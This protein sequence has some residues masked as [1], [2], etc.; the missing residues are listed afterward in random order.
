MSEREYGS[1]AVVG[2]AVPQA[3]PIVEPE[4]SALLPTGVSML[5][6]R[7]QGSRSDS[8]NRLID[9]LTNLEASL[10]MYD[11]AQLQVAGYACTG[12]SY[13]VGLEAESRALEKAGERFGYP[14][15]SSSQAI[16]D[17]LAH[18]GAK[19][20]ALFA[21]YPAW[22]TEASCAYWAAC[23]LTVTSHLSMPLDTTDTRNIY[24]TRTPMVMDAFERLEWQNADAILLSGTGMPT[25]RAIGEIH[26]RTGKPVVSSNLCL[27]WALAARVG[28]ADAL[29]PAGP[30]DTLFG[31]WSHR[32]PQ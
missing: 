23:G 21:P 4:M 5:V 25:L 31:G 9:Y 32:I 15:I 2:V 26:R 19:K 29:E 7:L 18:L 1:R 28:L 16:R 22:L 10:D 3:N 30:E 20:I 27:A 24:Q 6:T 8:R 13:L 17:A 14:I 12:S 11:T